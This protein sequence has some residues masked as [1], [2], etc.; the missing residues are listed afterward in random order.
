M[1]RLTVLMTTALGIQMKYNPTLRRSTGLAN[2]LL[3]PECIV[4]KQD[5]TKN[6]A[7]S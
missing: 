7:N 1:A 5:L 6:G 2:R 3:S 4:V